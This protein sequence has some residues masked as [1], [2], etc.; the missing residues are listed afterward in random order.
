LLIRIYRLPYDDSDTYKRSIDIIA[1]LNTQNKIKSS[2]LHSNDPRQV[3]LENRFNSLTSDF[4]YFRK[5]GDHGKKAGVNNIFMD[6]LALY[7]HVMNKKRPDD[8]VSGEVESYFEDENKYNNCFPEDYIKK[9]IQ[10]DIKHIVFN[11]IEC[12]RLYFIITRE[13][14]KKLTN[15]QKDLSEY[16]NWYLMVDSYQQLQAWKEKSFDNNRI[17]W[18]DFL[19]S[20]QFTDGIVKYSRERF[21]IYLLMLP[22]RETDPRKFFKSAEGRAKFLK[23]QGSVREFSKNMDKAYNLFRKRNF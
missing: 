3:L 9:D 19:T 11:Y 1:A 10:H 2:D 22:K 4:E 17:E 15:K 16:I 7:Y 6:K 5:R 23:N 14:A 8:G 12:W 20:S 13:L 18:I 21:G